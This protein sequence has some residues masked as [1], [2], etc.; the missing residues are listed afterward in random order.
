MKKLVSALSLLG[1]VL[2][3]GNA[4]A[5]DKSEQEKSK[6]QNTVETQQPFQDIG[7]RTLN[8][9]QDTTDAKIFTPNSPFAQQSFV[10]DISLILDSSYIYRNL[11]N[12]NFGGL[13]IPGFISNNGEFQKNGFNFNYAELSLGSTVDP[14]FD[15]MAVFPITKEGIEVEEAYINTRNLPFSFQIKAGKFRSSW[16]RLNS[17]HEHVWD[18]IDPPVIYT[19]LFGGEQLNETGVQ[20]NWLAPTDFY[21]L[22]GAE[23]FQGENENSFGT[24]GFTIGKNTLG[25]NNLPNL[26]T[27][28][29]KT[30]FDI[31]SNFTILGGLS[32]AHGGTRQSDITDEP[33][34]STGY[35]G[36]SNI[37]GADLT[38]K[39]FLDSYRY[40]SWQSEFMYRNSGGNTYNTDN[41]IP[42]TK[43]QSGLYSQIVWRFDQLWRTGIRYDLLTQNDV[44]QN[45]LNLNN[46]SALSRYS[47]MI[48]CN[49]SEF[50][51][52]R[53]QFNH[54]RSKY[55]DVIQPVNEVFL[56]LN[57][58]IG[59]HGA[60]AF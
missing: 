52:L 55:S 44:F 30:S 59:S 57:M 27:G 26:V 34:N 29:A 41:I 43:N 46:P 23:G 58:S 11:T 54:D 39:Y 16:G 1:F 4:W 28:F 17:Q 37:F 49:L 24:N 22:L 31:G 5:E 47:A 21:L 33:K 2:L 19:A 7:D 12:D 32:Y 45:N 13:K 60:H 18:F 6:S 35:D 40:L 8:L 36:I 42:T 10:P 48:E 50:S 9:N 56:Q 3:S 25:E 53:L 20:V 38:L 51:R 15:M 14:Y